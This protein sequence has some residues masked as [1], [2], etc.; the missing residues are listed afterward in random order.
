MLSLWTFAPIWKIVLREPSERTRYLQVEGRVA[1]STGDYDRA[2]R[3]YKRGWAVEDGSGTYANL[4][5][6]ELCKE[7]LRMNKL[8]EC[9]ETVEQVRRRGGFPFF[10]PCLHAGG[11]GGD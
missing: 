2:L 11:S 1:A 4:C 10:S 8:D 9:L 6:F 3:C 7:L 5:G